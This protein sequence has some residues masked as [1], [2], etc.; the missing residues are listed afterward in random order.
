[1]QP[2]EYSRTRHDAISRLADLIASELEAKRRALIGFDFAFGYPAGVAKHLTRAAS[3]LALWDWL[4]ARIRDGEDNANDRY[5]VAT[6]INRMYK[7]V[8][9]FWGRPKSWQYPDVPV[10]KSHRTHRAAHPPELRITDR[11]AK[12]VKTVW[13]L[14]YAGSVGS[15]VLLGL[16]AVKRLLA[17]SRIKGHAKVWPL[18]TGLRAPDAAVVIAEIYPSLLREEIDRRM[19]MGEGGIIDAVQVCVNADAF[20]T[21]DAQGGLAPL[22]DGP[23]DRDDGAMALT[24]GERHIVATEEAWIFGVGHEDA[25]RNALEAH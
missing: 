10:K 15:Q 17:D 24:S 2:P 13:Q 11:H 4:T 16:P 14:A 5:G 7:G 12:G 21:L 20:A 18:Q 3:G 23:P 25:L 1:M 8:G 6:E 9:P 19:R 22:F